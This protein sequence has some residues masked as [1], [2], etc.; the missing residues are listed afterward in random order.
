MPRGGKGV[1]VAKEPSRAR[2]RSQPAVRETD[3]DVGLTIPFETLEF[4]EFPYCKIV[5][6]S[7]NIS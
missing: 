4:L 7:Y 2:E 6:V 1:K 3:K 5:V